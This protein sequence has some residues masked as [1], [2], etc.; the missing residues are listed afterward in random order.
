MMAPLFLNLH[1]LRIVSGL[2]ASTWAG[3]HFGPV[4]GPSFPQSP[5]HVHPCSSFRQEQL[6]VRVCLWD[7]NPIPHLMPCLLAGGRLYKFPL[8]TVGISSEV[9]PFESWKPLTS[10]VSG[11]FCKLPPQHPTSWGCL[12]PFFS[13]GPQGFSPFLSPNN[14]PGSPSPNP[15]SH[16]STF[17]PSSFP[18]PLWLLSSY[19]GGTEP[20]SPSACLTSWVLWTVS[21]VFCISLSFLLISTYY[22]LHTMCVI[23][24]LSYLTQDDIF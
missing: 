20:S 18:T 2:G 11:T 3:S 1:S 14:R 23:L 15:S 13:A 4:P 8:S 21:L 9:L 17:S 10:H 5:L 22:W 12:L 6:W 16:L 7:G 24:C 19:S